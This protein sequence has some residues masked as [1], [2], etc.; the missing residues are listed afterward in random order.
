MSD[1]VHLHLHSEYSLLDGACRIKDIPRRA[2]ECGH[3]AVALTDHGVLYG[4]PAFVDACKRE[5]IKPIVGCEV[6]V[7]PRSRFD[8]GTSQGSPYHLVLLCKNEIGYRNLLELVSSGFVDGFYS[9]PRVDIELL[10]SHS[11]G[12]IALSA[13][14][15][16]RLSRAISAGDFDVAKSAALE[17]SEIFG[18]DN[19]YI[20]IQDHGLDEQKQ[21]LPELVRLA[22]ECELPLV[23]TNDCHYLRRKD[24]NTQAVL[25]CIQMN[26]VISDGRPIGFETDEFYY[27]DTAE[28][29]MLFGKYEGAI[30]NTVKIAQMC[31]FDMGDSGIVLPKFPCPRGLSSKEYLRELVLSGLLNRE[32]NGSITYA[33]HKREEYL[34]R[35]DYELSVIN[36]MGFSDY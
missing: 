21:I 27:K 1:F 36:S 32:K 12:L 22:R 20:E 6:Y 16:G 30:E 4:V 5:G 19:F 11:E 2:K 17:Y 26:K 10:R 31:N 15:A 18:R 33:E 29:E 34:E 25:M 28:M 14:L 35:I 13:C 23:A 7:A 9:K 24:A 8:K 3:S